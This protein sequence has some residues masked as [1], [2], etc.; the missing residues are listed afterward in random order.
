MQTGRSLVQCRAGTMAVG[1]DPHPQLHLIKEPFLNPYSVHKMTSDAFFLTNDLQFTYAPYDMSFID[2]MHLIENVL[3]D[4][5]GV[6]RN[7][8]IRSIVVI[9]D[10]LP[11]SAEITSREP[12]PG[13]WTGDVWRIYPTLKMARPDLTLILVNVAPTGALI[14]MNLEPKDGWRTTN[15]MHNMIKKATPEEWFAYTQLPIPHPDAVSVDVALTL[16]TEFLERTV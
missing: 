15:T 5:A 7:S 12:L 11:Y 4:F 13:D 3:R 16:V 10:V 6:E 2:G 9:D 14:I 8:H 1:V